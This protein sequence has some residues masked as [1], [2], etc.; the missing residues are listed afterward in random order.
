M[1]SYGIT[2]NLLA[3]IQDF[4]SNLWQKVVV[5]NGESTWGQVS[6]GVPLGSVLGPTLFFIFVNEIPA[7]VD[8]CTM[9]F[10]DDCKLYR[11]ICNPADSQK[12][13]QDLIELE[14]WTEEWLLK[15]NASKCKVMHLGTKNL[16]MDYQMTGANGQPNTLEETS[17]EKPLETMLQTH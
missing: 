10:A 16:H 7:L 2:G 17:V 15:F 1:F 12:L 14:K 13:Q 4:L 11:P 9:M 6:S 8:S 3:W 5:R